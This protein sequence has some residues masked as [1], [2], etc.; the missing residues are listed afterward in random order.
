MQL[1]REEASDFLL[2]LVDVSSMD[3]L[4][5]RS[6]ISL[7]DVIRLVDAY[8]R[9]RGL[10]ET[11]KSDKDYND[12]FK[13]TY[14]NTKRYS[15][16][17]DF[18]YGN[19]TE[20]VTP[21]LRDYKPAAAAVPDYKGLV[22]DSTWYQRIKNSTISFLPTTFRS[23]YNNNTAHYESKL[24]IDT[25]IK[26][27]TV[28]SFDT[29]APYIK[30]DRDE[31]R[32]SVNSID[33][34]SSE[35]NNLKDQVRALEDKL[36]R[37]ESE[38][39]STGMS[40]SSRRVEELKKALAEHD[41]N[42]NRLEKSKY[43]RLIGSSIEVGGWSRSRLWSFLRSL[44]NNKYSSLLFSNPIMNIIAMILLT[45]LLLNLLKLFYFVIL[46]FYYN[47]LHFDYIDDSYEDDVKVTVSWV[48]EIPWLEYTIYQFK[49]WAGY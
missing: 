39:R 8:P 2:R 11:Y 48:Q 45:I 27:E 22:E 9:D 1:H 21:P 5:S 43:N 35:L 4:F 30:R 6:N 32:V 36:L 41:A 3:Q 24:P 12:V 15:R 18:S 42:I 7:S 38:R 37:Y 16:I 19:A 10:Y 44:P 47:R 31:P 46:V 28:G 34:S 14:N 26:R 29:K 25:P 40:T 20:N 13:S 17:N 23:H 33:V 49:E